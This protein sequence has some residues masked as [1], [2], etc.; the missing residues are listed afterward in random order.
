MN[1]QK[2]LIISGVTVL[3]L[4]FGAL[5]YRA[6]FWTFVDN[7]EFAYRFDAIGGSL[8]PLVNSDGS[9][10]HGYVFSWPFIER[11]HTIDTRPMQVCINA[12]SRVLNCKLVH[13]NPDGFALFLKWH[14][15]GNY[16]S[17][18]LKDI[19]MS[20]AYDPSQSS[21]PFLSVLKELKNQDAEIILE[22]PALDSLNLL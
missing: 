19:L 21:Y 7:Y 11:I 9:P 6:L 14:G 3:T 16:G 13:F 20:Y 10:V 4:L 17:F 1:I 22:T 18:E 2:S 5:L 15:R 8:E 12:N